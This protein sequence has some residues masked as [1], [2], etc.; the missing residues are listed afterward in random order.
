M[1]GMK[2]LKIPKL[3]RHSVSVCWSAAS[4]F[5]SKHT[6]TTRKPHANQTETTRRR[7]TNGNWTETTLPTNG[8]RTAWERKSHGVWSAP[9]GFH[10]HAVLNPFI[11]IWYIHRNGNHSLLV[12]KHT[13][14]TRKPH[15]NTQSRFSPCTRKPHANQTDWPLKCDV[16]PT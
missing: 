6:E 7:V 4:G 1:V 14:T 3:W 5:R 15:R 11:Y 8:F 9:S 16:T 13:Q 12:G 10:S 2:V